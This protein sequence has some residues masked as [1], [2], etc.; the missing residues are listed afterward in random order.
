MWDAARIA[1]RPRPREARLGLLEFVPSNLVGWNYCPRV[2][3]KFW[4]L[5]RR[6]SSRRS[7][8]PLRGARLQRAWCGLLPAGTWFGRKPERL[9][10]IRFRLFA[11]NP[12]IPPGRWPGYPSLVR[13]RNQESSV[14]SAGCWPGSLDLRGVRPAFFCRW[15]GGGFGGHLGGVAECWRVWIWPWLSSCEKFVSSLWSV[16]PAMPAGAG[17]RDLGAEDSKLCS[18]FISVC[19]RDLSLPNSF[20]NSLDENSFVRRLEFLDYF[21]GCARVHRLKIL[22]DGL[23]HS[24]S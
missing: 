21:S 20:E 15:I 5:W 7:R 10:R 1:G 17:A 16:E 13:L 9:N 2:W 6:F 23:L 19:G 8:L 18:W 4:R 11:R 3:R 22:L 12:G 14:F 24:G